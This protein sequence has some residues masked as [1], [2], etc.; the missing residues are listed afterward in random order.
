MLYDQLSI[1]SLVQLCDSRD[2]GER[3]VLAV[4]AGG[5]RHLPRGDGLPADRL[6]PGRG[7]GRGQAGGRGAGVQKHEQADQEVTQQL[8]R[9]G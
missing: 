6:R 9:R 5:G 4:A 8:L 2:R 3:D 1:Q 7:R